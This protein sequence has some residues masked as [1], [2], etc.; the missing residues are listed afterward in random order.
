MRIAENIQQA[1]SSLW[2][3]KMRALLTMLGIIIGIAAVI[4]IITLGDSLSNSIS[5]SMQGMGANN[6]IVSLQSKKEAGRNSNGMFGMGGGGGIDSSNLVSD[7]MLDAMET[8]FQDEI[9]AVSLSASVGSGQ[10]TDGRLYA[11]L[12]VT[13]VN[14]GY[15][16]AESVTIQKGRFLNDRDQ[17]GRKKVAVVSDKLAS[18]MF[19]RENPLGRQITIETSASSGSTGT[20]GVYTIVGVY[21]YDAGM[22]GGFSASDKDVS[23]T[24]YIPIKTAQ[25][26]TGTD[27][28]SNF[29]VVTT[30]SA[31]SAQMATDIVNFFNRFYSHNPD[32]GVS[33][34]SM[35]SMLETVNSMLNNVKIAIAAIAA[36]SLLVGGIGVMNIMLVSI[37]ERT[38]EIGTRKAIGATNAAIR[39]QFIVE[40]VVICLIGGVIGITLGVLLGIFGASL[41]DSPVAISPSTIL[42]AAGFSM[43]V[44]VFFGYYPANK[45]A[46]LDPID[47]LRYE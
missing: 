39:M 18:N 25:K 40:A 17:D 36:I 15:A 43:M 16:K 21:K 12:S 29:T 26:L 30:A 27:G 46:K 38:R 28:Y 35:E 9:D 31:N 4:G 44:G 7:D 47:A 10:T 22:M 3:N 14:E 45:A 20:V 33:A 41:L 37:T 13:G 2:A 32:Y 23:T 11:N 1:F 5:G 8:E 19:G 42:L 34:F 6:I 24:V